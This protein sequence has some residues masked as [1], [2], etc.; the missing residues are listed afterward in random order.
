MPNFCINLDEREMLWENL[1]INGTKR[2]KNAQLGFKGG[3]HPIEDGGTLLAYN[4]ALDYNKT[5][6]NDILTNFVLKYV[7]FFI[8]MRCVTKSQF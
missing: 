5:I 1:K 2:Q 8:L 3:K 6:L 7:V 4:S